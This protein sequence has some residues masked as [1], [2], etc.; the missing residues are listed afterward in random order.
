MKLYTSTLKTACPVP[1]AAAPTRA[2]TASH[3]ARIPCLLIDRDG[4][5]HRDAALVRERVGVR[6][7]PHV[8]LEAAQPQA[9]APAKL[10]PLA[11]IAGDA[12]ADHDQAETLLSPHVHGR[13]PPR[14]EH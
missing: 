9:P 7:E 6:P 1:H 2:V 13:S 11:L 5:R 10:D 14:V 8:Q 12:A 4:R 3:F